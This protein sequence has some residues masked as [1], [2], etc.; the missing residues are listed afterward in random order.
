M[1]PYSLGLV[2]SY[3]IAAIDYRGSIPRAADIS[4]YEFFLIRSAELGVRTDRVGIA[5]TLPFQ[6]GSLEFL[7]PTRGRETI[8]R[9]LNLRTI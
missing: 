5:R 1:E 4:V 8:R 3:D 6:H 2:V 7:I 9:L